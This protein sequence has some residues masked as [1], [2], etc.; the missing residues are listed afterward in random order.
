MLL[1]NPSWYPL[2]NL[3]SLYKTSSS[4]PVDENSI[5]S[6]P[7]TVPEPIMVPLDRPRFLFWSILYLI[8]YYFIVL[9]LFI[10]KLLVFIM[11][12]LL[13]LLLSL[14]VLLFG[15]FKLPRPHPYLY[16]YTSMHVPTFVDPIID[17]M[18]LLFITF[19]L[20][21]LYSDTFMIFNTSE[22]ANKLLLV[23]QNTILSG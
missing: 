4:C 20:F 19:W 18:L 21:P 14:K 1:T 9:F 8:S 2:T 7:T 5:H 3:F 13:V 12:P 17:E 10:F 23:E 6:L 16:S 15:L 22:T 11:L